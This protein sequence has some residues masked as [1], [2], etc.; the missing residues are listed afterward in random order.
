MDYNEFNFQLEKC[1]Q[2]IIDILNESKMP[3]GALLY[4]IK[5]I[6]SE[7]NSQYIASINTYSIS[8][9]EKEEKESIDIDIPKNAQIQ[10]EEK[11]S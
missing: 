4:I 1:K 7:L 6:Y 11:Q 2:N 9:P 10:I 3:I 8:H 5:D